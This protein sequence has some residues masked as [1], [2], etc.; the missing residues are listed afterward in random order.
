VAITLNA[1]CFEG[2]YRRSLCRAFM[3]GYATERPLA[4]VEKGA[5][6]SHALFG[7]VRYAASRI[8]DFHLS[9]LPPER[10]FKKDFRTYLARTEALA[11]MGQKGFADLLQL[12]R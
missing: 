11:R 2:T 1:W 10:L 9:P 7:A 3:D 6:F 4:P 12:D 8:R 5:L